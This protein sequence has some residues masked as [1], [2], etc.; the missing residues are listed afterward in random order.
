[1]ILMYGP[2]SRVILLV[3]NPCA[4]A[5]RCRVLESVKSGNVSER[6]PKYGSICKGVRR[7]NRANVGSLVRLHERVPKYRAETLQHCLCWT[8]AEGI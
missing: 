3:R 6:L 1:M 4:V 8:Q 2:L 5:L 7:R